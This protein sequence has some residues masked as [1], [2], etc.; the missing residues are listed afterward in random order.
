MRSQPLFRP[1]CKFVILRGLNT[2]FKTPEIL[3]S[4]C[5]ALQTPA[6]R[7]H[8]RGCSV[9]RRRVIPCLGLLLKLLRSDVVYKLAREQDRGHCV[10]TGD[11]PIDTAHIYPNCLML[12]AFWPPEKIRRWQSEIFRD[13]SKPTDA[14]FNLLYAS[15]QLQR[16]I[17]CGEPAYLLFS[18][19]NTVQT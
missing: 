16:S 13:P 11:K 12:S 15:H 6:Y 7:S 4:L 1:V 14:C 18:R 10:I 17:E 8:M 3:S 5:L 19:L 2:S 9:P